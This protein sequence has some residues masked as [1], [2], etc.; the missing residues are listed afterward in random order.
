MTALAAIPD[1][2]EGP[3]T[4]IVSVTPEIAQK[5]L[6]ENDVNRNVR[7]YN[8]DKYA[9]NMANGQ[10]S[11]TGEP[12]KF[13]RHRK[14]L[15][16]QHRLLAVVKSG[17]TVDLLVVRNL[18]PASQIEMDSGAKRTAADALSFIGESSAALLA[19]TARIVI[20]ATTGLI[21]QDRKKHA[22]SNGEIA[23]F[24][25]DNPEIRDAVSVGE[26][27]R[28][29]ID[30]PPSVICAAYYCLSQV[31]AAKAVMFFDGLAS[32]A[33]LP[34]NSAILALDSRLRTIRKN[35]TRVSQ[36]DYLN[37]FFKAWN[38]WR[39]NR[40]VASLT[41]GGNLVEPS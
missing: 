29:A 37:L 33:N 20:L 41:L 34:K 14:L 8:V 39:K 26:R 2:E 10:W 24:V 22:L 3:Q 32:R 6:A 17:T 18:D 31:H 28:A 11:M 21:N 16:G 7:N 27:W 19:A 13:D 40:G 4:E 35:G 15:D 9:R 36:R 1:P 12:V 25:A 5:W 23:E 38:H 30:A